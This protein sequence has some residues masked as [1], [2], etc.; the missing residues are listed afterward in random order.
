[1][2]LAKALLAEL[3]AGRIPDGDPDPF[4]TAWLASRDLDA[5]IALVLLGSRRGVYEVD[6]TQT[7]QD[8][9]DAPP[10]RW[11]FRLRLPDQRYVRVDVTREQGVDGLRAIVPLLEAR[12][13]WVHGLDAAHD[14][15]ADPLTQ[16]MY[17]L[18]ASRAPRPQWLARWSEAGDP[19]AAAWRHSSDSV[20]M[21]QLLEMAGRT[22]LVAR[23][24]SEIH[25]VPMPPPG[26][27]R[28]IT[29][30]MKR[31]SEAYYAQLAEAVRRVVPT[32]P[33]LDQILARS[34]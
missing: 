7:W 24:Q 26:S 32:P 4:T 16:L 31:A 17:A 14:A 25:D 30:A 3:E 29:P 18:A 10:S 11:L 19:L 13:V 23:A 22:D 12:S 1:M 15:I 6:S 34:G 28:L 8:S 9:R 5:M 21:R 27:G 33:P 2:D 20:A